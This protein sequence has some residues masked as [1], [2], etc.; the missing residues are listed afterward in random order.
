MQELHF[1]RTSKL[2]YFI[3]LMFF[4]SS[5]PLPALGRY[6]SYRNLVNI[7]ISKKAAVIASLSLAFSGFSVVWLEWNTTLHTLVWLP[8]ALLAIEKILNKESLRWYIALGFSLTSI[9]FAGFLQT[10]F[11]AFA[12]IGFYGMFR[13]HKSYRRE[14][15]RKKQLLLRFSLLAIIVVAITAVQ[16]LPTARLVLNSARAYD[17]GNVLQREDWFLPWQHLVQ[18][19]APDFFGNPSTLNYWGVFN[20]MEFVG[21]I[22]IVPLTFA[23]FFSRP[24]LETILSCHSPYSIGFFNS[25]PDLK[26]SISTEDSTALNR[27]AFAAD[28]AC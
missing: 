10:A 9:L 4:S 1:W 5:F 7:G 16:W 24:D 13:V 19:I 6:R 20:Y 22:G 17:Q 27:P 15:D 8:L 25:K 2:P 14:F 12:C 11:Y 21:Y 3:P 26:T 23:F 28:D 18:F